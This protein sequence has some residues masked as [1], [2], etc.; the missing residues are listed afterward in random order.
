MRE[1][2]GK[3]LWDRCFVGEKEVR[4]LLGREE[5]DSGDEIE[6]KIEKTLHWVEEAAKMLALWQMAARVVVFYR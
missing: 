2:D 3:T 5:G 1:K 4:K 6:E